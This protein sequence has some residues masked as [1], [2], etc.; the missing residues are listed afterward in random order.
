M[1][2]EYVPGWFSTGVMVE[3]MN[4]GGIYAVRRRMI[5]YSW[6]TRNTELFD[7]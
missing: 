3:E 7:R 4:M 2:L 1:S 5:K 6:L